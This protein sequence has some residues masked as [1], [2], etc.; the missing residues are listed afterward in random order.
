MGA[1]TADVK[2]SRGRVL[3][4]ETLPGGLGL[5]HA[6]APLA[7]VTG[8]GSKLLG[9][10]GGQGHFVMEL[11]HYEPMLAHLQTKVTNSRHLKPSDEE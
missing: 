1:V 9:S 11:D 2:Q 5:V 4:M 10:T 6:Q 8:Y 7:D 3:G